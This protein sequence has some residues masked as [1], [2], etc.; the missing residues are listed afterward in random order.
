MTARQREI[1]DAARAIIEVDGGEALTMQRLPASLGIRASSLYKHSRTS[2]PSRPPSRSKRSPPV[3]RRVTIAAPQ[4]GYVPRNTRTA[5][6]RRWSSAAG[7]RLSFAK[8]LVT[9]LS[10]ARS[11]ITAEVL[12]LAASE[13]TNS[14]LARS[15]AISPRTVE[16]HLQR[17]YAKLGVRDRSQARAL[18]STVRRRP[19]PSKHEGRARNQTPAL[20]F[21]LGLWAMRSRS[22]SAVR[23]PL[24]TMPVS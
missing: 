21:H 12:T 14:E 9:C 3:M 22:Y 24:L 4:L 23:R 10:T 7:A 20:P 13:R 18:V 15:L 8:I 1:V 19:G 5:R 2:P 11:V 16:K 6:T 17:C